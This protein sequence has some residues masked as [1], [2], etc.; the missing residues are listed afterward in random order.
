[1][2]KFRI[3]LGLKVNNFKVVE[4]SREK[5]KGSTLFQYWNVECLTCAYVFEVRQDRLNPSNKYPVNR[6]VR[7][8]STKHGMYAKRL[9]SIWEGIKQ[10]CLNPKSQ[11]YY[12]Y[13][14]RGITI[15]DEWKHSP[16][17]FITYCEGLPSYISTERLQ[18]DRIDVNGNYEPGNIR[19]VPAAINMR[20]RR[21]CM[22]EVDGKEI[23]FRD[24]VDRYDTN[25]LGW[26][27]IQDRMNRGASFEDAIKS[28][29]SKKTT[30][31]KGITYKGHLM[32]IFEL[33][34]ACDGAVSYHS[35][36]RRI[37]SGM[38]PEEAVSTPTREWGS[39]RE[40][41]KKTPLY[42]IFGEDLNPTL[43]YSKYSK[44]RCTITTFRA[45][46]AKGW[47]VYDALYTPNLDNHGRIAV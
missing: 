18:I 20:N 16:A 13:G 10:R 5:L 3:S 19:F 33:Y 26:R 14:G 43:A 45:R 34:E 38:S 2:G 47:D 41:S 11:N 31:Y 32:S 9:Y 8:A 30:P 1:M 24:V 35:L 28:T 25:K 6:C 7:C 29:S 44:G 42:R 4:F 37:A 36:K 39:N 15:C 12:N 21:L 17:V 46:L 40:G 27:S 22:I 23:S